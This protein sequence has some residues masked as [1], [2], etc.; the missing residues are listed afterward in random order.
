[1]IRAAIVDDEPLVIEHIKYA[2]HT[3]DTIEVVAAYSNAL[4]ALN[5][6]A[7]LQLDVLFLDIKMPEIDG[8][9]FATALLERQIDTE[10]IFVTAFECYAVKAF[11][12]AALDY[13]LKPV[14]KNRLQKSISRLNKAQKHSIRSSNCHIQCFRQLTVVDSSSNDLEF[15]SSKSKELFA[16]LLFNKA[17]VSKESIINTIWP[18]A[19]SAK[20]LAN[21]NTCVYRIR[22]TLNSTGLRII[23]S[24]GFYSLE[25]TGMQM[26]I[27]TFNEIV[28][29]VNEGKQL[30]FST[31]QQLLNVFQNGLMTHESYSWLLSIQAQYAENMYHSMLKIAQDLYS[32]Q[33]YSQTIQLLNSYLRVENHHE[34][35]WQLLINSYRAI[36]DRIQERKAKQQLK[37]LLKEL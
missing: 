6:L 12:V 36:G 16:F 3:F 14:N 37:M 31:G 28:N 26:D 18:D 2:L 27:D 17:K 8:L 13:I 11:E 23:Y 35:I 32:S 10:I 24:K 1:M 19:D 5:E 4:K 29:T 22:K 34:D 20:A 21:L 25:L 7:K 30:S 9:A 33:Q 15:I